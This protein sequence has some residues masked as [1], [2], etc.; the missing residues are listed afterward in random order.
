MKRESALGDLSQAVCVHAGLELFWLCLY[1]QIKEKL[2]PD[3]FTHSLAVADAAVTMG[4]TFGGDLVKTAIAG[5]LHDRA[6]DMPD[7]ELLAFAQEHSLISDQS[8]IDRPSLLHGPVAACLAADEWGVDDEDILQS[9]RYHTTGE[10]GLCKEA[11][12]VFMADLIEPARSYPGVD[13]LRQLCRRDLKAAMIEALQQTFIYV[14]R[15]GKPL[16]SGAR[17][18]LDWLESERSISWKAKS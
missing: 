16:H 10:A 15:V 14:E 3:R 1:Q 17:R 7:S 6:K 18:C 2:S 5:M 9:I 4:R 13:T 12:I 11:C 8:E